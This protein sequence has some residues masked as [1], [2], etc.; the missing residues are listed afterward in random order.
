LAQGR[1]LSLEP[2]FFIRTKSG[3]KFMVINLPQQEPELTNHPTKRGPYLAARNHPCGLTE[4][5][6][7]VLRL[8]VKGA[9]NV[10]IAGTLKRSR[11]TIE[12]HV[13]GILTKLGVANRMEAA[14]CALSDPRLLQTDR[15]KIR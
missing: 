1:Q 11:R 2:F 5:E 3:S 13:S 8:M 15:T 9:N 4:K 10:R 6:V 14:L 7:E 12:H